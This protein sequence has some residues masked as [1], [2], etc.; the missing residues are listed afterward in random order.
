MTDREK[1]LKLLFE[2]D[3]ICQAT[4]CADGTG[5]KYCGLS[6]CCQEM[7]A[8]HLLANGVVV[9]EEIA[10]LKA[11]NERLREMWAK[12]VVELSK[13]K[14]EAVRSHRKGEWRSPEGREYL[15]VVCDNCQKWSDNK[16]D[17]C[18]NCGADMRK[19]ENG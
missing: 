5:C 1:L 19:G 11:D 17:F 13:A 15:G 10:E 14:A 16:F 3:D 4:D 12:T 8:D 6:W 18:P 9:S 2:T 7:T